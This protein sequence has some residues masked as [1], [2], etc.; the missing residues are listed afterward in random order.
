MDR[1]VEVPVNAQYKQDG[2][3]SDFQSDSRPLP[4]HCDLLFTAVLGIEAPYTVYWQVV[5]TGAEAEA[6][7][8]KGLRGQIFASKTAGIG[9]RIQK[10]STLYSGMH[11]IQCFVVKGDRCVALSREFVVNIQ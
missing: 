7:G 6:Q 5:N 9:G 3:W 2:S 11:W 10:E 4:K 8:A 1:P